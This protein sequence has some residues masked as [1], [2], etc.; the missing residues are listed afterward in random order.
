MA[1]E[2]K[3][4]HLVLECRCGRMFKCATKYH[5]VNNVDVGNLRLRIHAHK[6]AVPGHV[7][8]S[9]D[10][11]LALTPSCWN[12][13]WTTTYAMPPA[14]QQGMRSTSRSTSRSRSRSRHR[15]VPPPRPTPTLASF[16]EKLNTMMLKLDTMDRKLTTLS[17]DTNRR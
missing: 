5:A 2:N 1:S 13:E 7:E 9:W 4:V 8:M 11:I 15:E 10:D 17:R 14:L 3:D 12:V 6:D 16:D